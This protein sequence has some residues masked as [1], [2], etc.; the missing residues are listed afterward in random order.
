MGPYL[1][2]DLSLIDILRERL[3]LF[4]LL[5]TMCSVLG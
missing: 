3:A 2:R 5:I 4:I 1:I